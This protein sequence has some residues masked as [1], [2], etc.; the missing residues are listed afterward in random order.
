MSKARLI[1]LVVMFVLVAQSLFVAV[2]G[3]G[4]GFFDGDH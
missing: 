1:F 2:G 3:T 4:L